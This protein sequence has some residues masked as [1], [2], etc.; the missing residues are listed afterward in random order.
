M[1][2][3]NEKVTQEKSRKVGESFDGKTYGEGIEI[4]N[5]YYYYDTHI[6]DAGVVPVTLFNNAVAR[7]LSLT[8]YPYQQ[9][10]SGQSFDI[11]GMRVSYYSHALAADATQQLFLDWI[12][13]TV[14]QVQ[15]VNKV[16]SFERNLAALLGGQVQMV[17][18]PA[19]TVGSRNLSVWTGNTVV[20]FKQKIYVDRQT[21]WFVRIQRDLANNAALTGDW[22]RV[23][24][25]GV[26]RQQT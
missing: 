19:V 24:M 9:L 3:Q 8:N 7:N 12:Q 2:L 26:L 25:V 23:E 17:T 14:L 6:L 15:I 16:P 11:T 22:L 10:P 18:A 1:P 13:N 5:P 20:K 21:P 4:K